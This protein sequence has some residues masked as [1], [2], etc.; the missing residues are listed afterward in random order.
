MPILPQWRIDQ[1]QLPGLDL[2][3][4]GKVRNTYKIPK[5]PDKLLQVAT[6][7]ISIFDFCLGQPIPGKGMILNAMTHFWLTMLSKYGI[8]HHM[9][10]WG[11][12]IDRYLP[13]AMQQNRML[14]T[15]G[16]IVD[17]AIVN[18]IEFIIR[19]CLTGSGLDRY[20]RFGKICGHAL[21]DGLQDGDLLPFLL[22]TPTTKADEGH[23]MPIRFDE[24]RRNFPEQTMLALQIFQ[25]ISRH[26]QQCGVMFADTKFEFGTDKEGNLMLIDEV[27]TPDSS[28]FWDFAKWQAGRSLSTRKSPT[29]LDKELARAWGKEKG[30]NKSDQ[31]DPKDPDHCRQVHKMV[32]P[33]EL[34]RS[35]TQTYRYIFWRLTGETIENYLFGMG[36]PLPNRDIGK[37]AIVF[38][39]E[40]DL[41]IIT[42]E[43]INSVRNRLSPPHLDIDVHVV[44]CH[45]NPYELT[46]FIDNQCEGASVLIAAGGMAL[47]LPGVLDAW[48][49]ADNHGIPVV[50]LALGEPRTEPFE[51]ARLSIKCIPGQP[52]I[53]DEL[54][55]EPYAN[56]QG[57]ESIIARILSGEFPPPPVR[58]S[59]PAKFNAL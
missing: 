49:A 44:S 45:R 4:M 51:A 40:S 16:M 57:F 32:M 5:H 19:Q 50:G 58:A 31:F 30:I 8:A 47:A 12:D 36:V 33:D 14:Q 22:D 27:G 42:P 41:K 59:K 7:G 46:Q 35:I 15:Q 23:D 37:I 56:V 17:N 53:M 29:S 55:G 54:T 20:L 25:I 24:A 43:M 52:V 3:H 11:D 9:R 38:G 1:A 13:A 26:A 34:I 6:D 10:V 48:L 18:K 39:S 28:R 21:P 2:L